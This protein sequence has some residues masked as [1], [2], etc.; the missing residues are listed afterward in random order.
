MKLIEFETT[1]ANTKTNQNK[2]ELEKSKFEIMHL[3][4]L[5]E[6]KSTEVIRMRNELSKS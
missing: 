5:V 6:E 4:N 3:R 1:L 2:E